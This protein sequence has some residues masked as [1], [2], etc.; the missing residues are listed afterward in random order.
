MGMTVTATVSE[1]SVTAADLAALRDQSYI[2]SEDLL[3]SIS[4]HGGCVASRVLTDLGLTTAAIE[5]G[6]KEALS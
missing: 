6:I 1:I 4:L 3:L 2:T 5:K